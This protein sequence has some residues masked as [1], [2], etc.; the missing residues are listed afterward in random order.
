MKEKTRLKMMKLDDLA[1]FIA[2]A[3]QGS[4]TK[5][6]DYCSLPKSTVSRHIRE[7]E[8]EL[9]ILCHLIQLVLRKI[10][11]LFGFFF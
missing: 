7:L 8:D 4:F 1:M 9:N 5:A 10:K 2:V 11:K 3:E 6:A